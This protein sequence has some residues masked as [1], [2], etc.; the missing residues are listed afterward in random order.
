MT[1]HVGIVGAGT[2]GARYLN[3]LGGDVENLAAVAIARRDEAAGRELAA[4]HDVAWEPDGAALIARDDVD[5]VIVATPPSTHAR[6]AE[7]ALAAG[8]PVLV[9]KPVT[10]TVAEARALHAT[11]AASGVV[12]MVAQTLR[13]NPV[14]RRSRELWP[15][16][17]RV[18]HVR[19]AQRLEPTSLAWQRDPTQTVGGSVL[20]TGV[21]I[22]DLARWLT[23][24]EVVTVDS[25][26]WQVRNP[27]VE[28]FF[29]CRAELDDGCQ[30]SFEVSK[31]TQ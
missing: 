25:R 30:V 4:R 28:D 18:H 13:W 23:G 16:L 7:L 19:L 6:F 2:H 9:E 27:V 8:R 22:F 12:C 20:L 21:H 31:Y 26:Q 15:R 14:L 17:G 24:H 10:G 1:L 5:A 11:A 29:L 3:H